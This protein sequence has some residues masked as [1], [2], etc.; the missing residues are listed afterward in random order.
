[1]VASGVHQWTELLSLYTLA[2][3]FV[4]VD[5]APPAESDV[6]DTFVRDIRLYNV[7][8]S[9]A[10]AGRTPTYCKPCIALRARRTEPFVI[11]AKHR[12]MRRYLERKGMP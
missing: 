6:V 8:P 9:R 1:M 12:E 5:Y 4:A 2:V 10:H 11:D 7:C 3:L